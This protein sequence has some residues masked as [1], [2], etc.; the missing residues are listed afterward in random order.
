MTGEPA[1]VEL[2][3]LDADAARAFYG[4]LLGWSPTGSS[5]SGQVDTAS[6]SIGIHDGDPSAIFE[7]FFAVDDLAAA[8]TEVSRLRGTVLGDVHDSPGFG[9]W[10]ECADDQGTRFGLRQA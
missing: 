10:A 2:G 1:Y 3:V 7:V 4:A 8:L 6:L 5:G 9:T